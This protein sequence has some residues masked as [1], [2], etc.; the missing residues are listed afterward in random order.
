[1]S[2]SADRSD[3]S[4]PVRA[5][6]NVGKMLA[7]TDRQESVVKAA[8]ALRRHVPGGD[9]TSLARR[10]LRGSDR[11]AGLIEQVR[12]EHPSA[13]RELGLA[14]VQVWQSIAP[15]RRG[16][17]VDTGPVTILFT[18]LVSF[19]TWALRV[20]DDKVLELLRAVDKAS[21]EI[22]AGR[23]GRVVKSL[24]DGLMAVFSD[25]AE[26]IWAAHE[27]AAAVSAITVD[28]YRP[29]LRCGLHTGTPRQVGEDYLGVDVNIAARISAA[30][31]AGEVLA[32]AATLEGADESRFTKRNKRFRA[33]GAPKDLVVYSVLPRYDT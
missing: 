13:V 12:A 19:S 27:T 4:E 11:I 32:S 8:Q 10:D 6:R 28:G 31:G 29:Q 1:M 15:R 2:S 18:D 3:K 7:Q 30:A 33:K 22:I 21:E 5:A 23:G 20:G 25:P 9:P 16:T 24:G 26:A 17:D 14:A